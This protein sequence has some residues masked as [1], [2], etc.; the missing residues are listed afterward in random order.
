MEF[1]LYLNGARRGPF[2][3][4]QV[5]ALLSEGLLL[6]TDL[7]GDRPDGNWQ[8]LAD[9]RRFQ[10]ETVSG[11]GNRE[12]ALGASSPSRPPPP[13]PPPNVTSGPR[14]LAPTDL[15]PYSR[16]TLA[17]DEKAY[18]KTSLHWFIFARFA[19]AGVILFI[20]AAVP[21]AIAVQA[22]TG[23]EAG[24]FVLPLPAFLLV[25]PAVAFAS[26]EI[27]ITDRRV[28]IKT[29]VIRRQT[30]EM[31]ISKVESI[32]VDQGFLGRLF[33]FGTVRIRGTG[34]F[35]E[36][37]DTIARPLEFRNWVQRVQGGEAPR[38]LAGSEAGG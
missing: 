22:L 12:P 19:G 32:A 13:A 8:P 6:P 5:Q 1:Y 7:A 2:R 29:G 31:F 9:F 20:F 23:S 4:E 36:S 35:E 10:A 21:F 33:N 18:Y 16:S 26:S 37:F 27:V 25:A 14:A 3:E 17:P 28:L 11:V 24:W 34:G 30:A 38:G 15:G